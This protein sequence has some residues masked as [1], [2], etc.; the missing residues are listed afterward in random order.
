MN[1]LIAA[2]MLIAFIAAVESTNA[3]AERQPP[4]HIEYCHFNEGERDFYW[5]C[6]DIP[7]RFGKA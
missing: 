1:L 3:K 5:P 6:K 7:D 2:A 4:R